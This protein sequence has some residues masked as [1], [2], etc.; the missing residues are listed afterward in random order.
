[1]SSLTNYS[2]YSKSMNGNVAVATYPDPITAL[3][4]IIGI[5]GTNVVLLNVMLLMDL[6]IQLKLIF[7]PYLITKLLEI[8]ISVVRIQRLYILVIIQ[9]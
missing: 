8:F 4:A 1:M 9:T 6:M 5:V 7:A 2:Y 3:N